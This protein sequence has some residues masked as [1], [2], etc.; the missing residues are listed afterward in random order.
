MNAIIRELFDRG[1]AGQGA[2]HVLGRRAEEPRQLP[3]GHR[4]Q[5]LSGRELHR[6]AEVGSAASR[7]NLP[8]DGLGES[9]DD[10]HQGRSI[11][12]PEPQP[13]ELWH[14]LL[15][16]SRKRDLGQEIECRAHGRV[17]GGVIHAPLGGS[18]DCR[19]DIPDIRAA[20]DQLDDPLPFPGLRQPAETLMPHGRSLSAFGPT[21]APMGVPAISRLRNEAKFV[22]APMT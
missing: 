11:A 9:R 12:E 22:A 7:A 18:R 1:Q 14:E 5:A 6:F 20:A 16:P 15:V 19:S 21:V 8:I 4:V 13:A 17:V 10:L 3:P 2:A